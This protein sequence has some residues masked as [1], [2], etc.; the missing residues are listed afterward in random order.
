VRFLTI[1]SP[2]P[3]GEIIKITSY[4]AQQTQS[5][6]N[7]LTV[8]GAILLTYLLEWPLRG[9]RGGDCSTTEVIIMD[10]QKSPPV[11]R[12]FRRRSLLSSSAFLKSRRRF[13]EQLGGAGLAALAGPLRGENPKSKINKRGLG[14]SQVQ[15]II[16]LCQE[17]HSFDH[18][19]GSYAGLPSGYGI[20]AGYTSGGQAPFHFTTLTDNNTDPNHDWDAIHTG[21]A[22]GAMNGWYAANG[23]NA[24]GYYESSDL[25]YYYSLIPQYTL[26]V[27]YFCGMLSDTQPNR[28]ILY[29]GT[30]GGNCCDCIET[31]GTLDSSTYPCILDLLSQY[32]ITFANYNFGVPDNYSYLALWSNWATGGANNEL[33]QSQTQFFTDCTNNA[34]PNVVFITNESPNDEHPP[35][36]IQTGEAQMQQV[37]EAV[38]ASPAWSSSV[39]LLTYDEGGGFFEHVPPT[40]LDAY[41]PGVRVPL[42]IISPFAKAGYFDTVFQC[43][44]SQLKFIEAV[45]GLPTLASINSSFNTS[46][47]LTNNST[48]G[49][50]FPPRDGNSAT[51]NLTQC[52]NFTS[53]PTFE[54]AASPASVNVTQGNSGSSTVTSSVS[55]GFDDAVALSASGMPTGVTASF[56]PS[57]IAAP[58]SGS[59]TLTLTVGTS[60]ATGTYTITV[61]GTGGGVTQ[62][63]TVSLTITSGQSF[64]LSANPASVS[65]HQGGSGTS[66]ITSTVAGGFSSAVALSASGMPS[67]VTATF[68]P[69]SI[70][71]PGSGTSTL[72][73]NASSGAAAGTYT[74]TVTG[75]G[76]GVTQTTTISLTITSST[77]GFTLTAGPSSL[78]VNQGSNGTS[79]ITSSVSGGFDSAVSLSA[80]GMPSGVTAAF[81]PTS[82]ASPGSGSST[83]TLTVSNSAATGTYT[84]TVTGKGGGDTATT[85]VSLSVAAAAPS[86]TL[87]ASPGSVTVQQGGHGTS[88]I[89][90]TASGGFD[91]AIALSASGLPSGV[92]AS[93]NPAS[94]PSPGSGSST[95]TLTI[96]SSAATGAYT[97]NVIGSGSDGVVENTTVTLTVTSAS[98]NLVQNGSFQT[99]SFTDWTVGGPVEPT[100]TTAETHSSSFSALLGQAQTPEV[101][102]TSYIYQT[103]SI[104]STAKAA[105]LT[106]W[107]W[108]GT[109]DN[110]DYAYQ[111]CLIQSTSG[112]TDAT[113]MKVCSNTQTWTQV[114]YNLSKYIGK[115]IRLYFGVHGN[116]YSPDYVY[117]Y[118]DGISIT[119]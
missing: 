113:V 105:T 16:V 44:A 58:G 80:S 95:L 86:F 71:A 12:D 74:I 116:G 115:T 63:T 11:P 38:Q 4:S 45:F 99:G 93:F 59:T 42:L 32:G 97:I 94:I 27:N 68:S 85:T 22:D 73:F 119:L 98:P 103:V 77:A 109:N 100:I 102:G 20:P 13:L 53:S 101:D 17:N 79:T 40:Q 51:G 21:Y 62:T 9:I 23:I 60:A 90:A 57:S 76:G 82:I 5:G 26:C 83:L 37:I 67:S 91:G 72:T 88:T 65:V 1:Y 33:N 108:P 66:T 3:P 48:N 41:G 107:Y 47:P 25:A 34:L 54:L 84:I 35:E 117:M 18:Y 52:F 10:N 78:T 49:A 24:L 64:T 2:N 61:T 31:N 14:I 111:E 69:T 112:S 39:I 81:N 96:S 56:N 75:T 6:E 106:F 15:H 87:T 19:F 118:V 36:D 104:P 110:I 92:T 7:S 50:P 55:G 70:A 30:S 114:T 28:M 46:T 89:T 43:H 8:Q 29:S